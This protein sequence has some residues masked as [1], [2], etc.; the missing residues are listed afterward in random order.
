MAS[1]NAFKKS[2]HPRTGYH[3]R[4]GIN[5]FSVE[6][7][8]FLIPMA[9][10]FALWEAVSRLN[11]ISSTSLPAPS[12]ILS[13]L[14][15]NLNNPTFVFSAFYSL[16]NLIMGI[17]LG[18]LLALPLAIATGLKNKFDHSVT[19]MIVIVG[20]L[21]DLALLP[22]FVYWFGPGVTAVILM[23]T[24][25]AF[26]PIFFTV[27]EGVRDIPKDYFHVAAIYN[28][29][30]FD[31]YRKLVLPAAFPQLVTGLRLAY[32]FLWEIVI[33]LEILAAIT[34]IGSFINTSVEGGSLTQ[35]FAGIFMV[36]IIAVLID[37]TFFQYLEDR[38]RK[39]HE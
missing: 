27:R 34:G 5:G 13:V 25:V 9:L 26:F 24:I 33:A 6:K 32:E 2:F 31:V 20:A 38:V 30:K 11:I 39:W 21:P 7:V 29:R 4:F 28:T 16:S 22:I 37:R 14:L 35:A 1:F 18:F 12:E 3:P 15:I 36:G 8:L 23:A 19:P 10:V 17:A